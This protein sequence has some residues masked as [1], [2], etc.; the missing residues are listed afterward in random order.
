MRGNGLFLWQ[1]PLGAFETTIHI[2][3]VIG[4]TRRSGAFFSE[5]LHN[6]MKAKFHF[7]P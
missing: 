4:P 6:L 1:L 7:S 5:A 3:T 2:K